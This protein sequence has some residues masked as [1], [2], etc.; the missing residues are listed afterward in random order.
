MKIVIRT[1]ASIKIG[2]GHVMRCLTLAV[3]LKKNGSDITF[4]SRA[5]EGNLNGL[6]SDKGMKVVELS[7]PDSRSVPVGNGGS[8]D[9]AEWLGVTQE[10]D[11]CE[12]INALSKIIPDW[13][14]V[15]HYGLDEAWETVL[16]THVKNIMV[17]DDLA[18]RPHECDLILDQNWF[19]N[20]ESRYNGLVPVGCTQLFG[21]EYALL[22]PEFTEARKKLKPRKGDV[23][24]IF[25]FFGGSDP[26]NLTVMT[27]RALSAPELANL[28]VDIVIGEN[29]PHHEELKKITASRASTYLYVQVDD[30]AAVMAKADLVI[31]S[32]GMNT[33]ERMCLSIPSMVISFAKNQVIIL[34]DLVKNGFLEHLGYISEIN[35]DIIKQKII[36]KIN[37]PSLLSN[38]INKIENLINGKGSQIVAEWLM[39]DLLNKAWD[40]KCATIDKIE[41]YW[42]WVNDEQ[43]RKSSINNKPIPFKIHEKWFKNKLDDNNC[44]LY[45]IYIDK[46]PVGQV[47]FEAERNF[48]RID[49][50][51][52]KQFRGRK[53]G[54]RLLGLAITEFQKHSNQRILGEV[55]SSNIASGKI[56]ESLGFNVKIKN[57]NKIYTTQ[58]RGLEK[59]N[60]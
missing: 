35:Q 8:D 54:K 4:I 5:H 34:Q 23:K 13:L 3:E 49:Y 50:S 30:M 14:I 15:D 9:Y 59:I 38:Q 21:P 7:A 1:D 27:L 22:R 6:I 33:W 25:V 19:E 32:G 47:R 52:A 51:I 10:Q 12:S 2:S 57:E 24:R 37:E 46:H 11:A 53:L 60:A 41:L 18:N 29:N 28:K 20:K 16:R 43:V 40:V 48:A 42:V 36:D 17:I 44:S 31:G 45:M 39:G 55:L 58:L 26:H 56:F